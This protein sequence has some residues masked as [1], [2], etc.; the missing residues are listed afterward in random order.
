MRARIALRRSL[1]R[2]PTPQEIAAS[3]GLGVSA[4]DV[5]RALDSGMEYVFRRWGEPKASVD[6]P[7]KKMEA[8]E[9]LKVQILRESDGVM[10]RKSPLWE[11]TSIMHDIKQKHQEST[12]LTS[13][14]TL[15][16]NEGSTSE[17]RPHRIRRMPSRYLFQ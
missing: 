8:D 5:R 16:I 1:G 9:T 4:A 10:K 14:M 17:H 12:A 3:K 15:L 6:K 7:E 2:E 11:D 13:G